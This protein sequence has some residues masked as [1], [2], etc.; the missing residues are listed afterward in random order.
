MN[1]VSWC[2]V[3]INE[4]KWIVKSLKLI[5]TRLPIKSLLI[6]NLS[7]HI[8]SPLLIISSFSFRQSAAIK[9]L[10]LV[11]GN[12]KISVKIMVYNEK[13]KWVRSFTEFSVNYGTFARLCRWKSGEYVHTEAKRSLKFY[14]HLWMTPLRKNLNIKLTFWQIR[15]RYLDLNSLSSNIRSLKDKIFGS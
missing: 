4:M 6:I 7:Y 10:E 2:W 14:S 8:H 11:K 15:S 12:K 13:A 3:V 1:C 5:I 9:M